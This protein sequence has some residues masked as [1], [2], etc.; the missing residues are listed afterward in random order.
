MLRDLTYSPDVLTFFEI[1]NTWFVW[2]EKVDA[3]A[4]S[5]PGRHDVSWRSGAALLRLEL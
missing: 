4:V 1:F 2:V 5:G 3:L